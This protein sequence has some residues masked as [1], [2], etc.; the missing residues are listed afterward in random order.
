MGTD[1]PKLKVLITT[2]SKKKRK[3]EKKN[4]PIGAG[5]VDGSGR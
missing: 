5:P 3:K 2:L 4:R 1:E